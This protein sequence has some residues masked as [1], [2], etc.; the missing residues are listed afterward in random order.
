MI[1][2]I[3]VVLVACQSPSTGALSTRTPRVVTPTDVADQAT[4]Q[5]TRDTD[6]ETLSTAST[7]TNAVAEATPTTRRLRLGVS[8][9]SIN[10][11]KISPPKVNQPG[12]QFELAPGVN[13]DKSCVF[14]L[15][16]GVNATNWVMQIDGGQ[17]SAFTQI[18]SALVCGLQAEQTV[19]FTIR[20]ANGKVVVGA[21]SIA[22]RGGDAFYATWTEN[23]S[24]PPEVSTDSTRGLR[25]RLDNSDGDQRCIAVRVT[26]ISADGWQ[27][28]G[29]GLKLSAPFDTS[30]VA[31]LCGLSRQQEFTFSVYDAK[32]MTVTGGTGI[33]ARGGDVFVAEWGDIAG[34]QEV[35][36]ATPVPA[37]KA[38]RVA[39][40]NSDD[41]PRCISIQISG[42]RTNGWVLKADGLK[43][44]ANFDGAGNARMC[45]LKR[46]QE[47]TFSIFDANGGAVAGGRGIPARGG[48]IFAAEWR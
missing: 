26:G 3:L 30:G 7:P 33:P 31:E 9:T 43:A 48:N 21:K 39:L 5:P 6:E 20:D 4:V 29:D 41:D 14:V 15:V 1:L 36:T 18:G 34:A 8:A 24:N 37:A 46:K 13:D 23:P 11:N 25:F 47:F 19:T 27:I 16:R 45:G 2:G 12:L 42:I 40:K 10:T 28:K 17:S 44:S 22:A 38:L 32:E 35:A